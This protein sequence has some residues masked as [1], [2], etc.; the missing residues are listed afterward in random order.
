VQHSAENLLALLNDILDYSRIEAGKLELE[1]LPFHLPDL[2]QEVAT[3]LTPV[4]SAKS[5]EF[6]THLDPALPT[7]VYGD[8]NR[9]RQVLLNL[10]ANAIKFTPDGW[11]ALSAEVPASPGAPRYTVS[12]RDSGI[13]IPPERLGKLFEDFHQADSTIARKYGGTGL[14]LAISRRLVEAMRG[15]IQVESTLGQGTCF[16]VELPLEPAPLEAPGLLA[17]AAAP[18][19]LRLPAWEVL[20]V[21]D[22]GVNRLIG[23]RMLEKLGCVV[24]IAVDGHDAVHQA[25]SA[26]FDAI[27]MDLQMPGLNGI[28]A[29][30]LLRADGLQTPIVALT[31]SIDAETRTACAAA[32]MDGF[33]GKPFRLAD[34]ADILKQAIHAGQPPKHP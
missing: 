3:L 29:V 11:V 2:L 16:T 34:V 31:A 8:P 17:A 10:I 23:A 27:L 33:L 32:G 18:A 12:V 25:R 19:P 7:T 22:N 14:G 6:R 13:G 28:E 1:R 30:R 4:A 5:L 21:D 26:A 9:L 15:R 20:L 24:S